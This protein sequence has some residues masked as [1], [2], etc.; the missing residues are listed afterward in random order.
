MMQNNTNPSMD[1]DE[2]YIIGMEGHMGHFEFS[3]SFTLAEDFF[4]N[5]SLMIPNF[6]TNVSDDYLD[7]PVHVDELDVMLPLDDF[8]RDLEKYEPISSGE[9]GD[10]HASLEVTEGSFHSQQLPVDGE[11]GWSLSKS[12]NSIDI[13]MDVTSIQPTLILPT[14]DMELD[15]QLSI[16]HLVQAFGEAMEKEQKELADAIVKCTREKV[17]P[18]GGIVERLLYYLFQPF[19]KQSDYLR[20]ES[21][22]NFYAAFKAFY[23]IFPYGRFAHF[24]ANSAIIHAMPHDAEIIHIVDFDMGEGVQWSSIIDA[25]G[26]QQREVRLTSIKCSEKDSNCETL[27][28]K[29]EETKRWLYDHAGS[30][31]LKL[32]VEEMELQ[33]LVSE[34]KRMKR[35]VQRKEWLVFNCNVGLPHMGRGRSRRHVMEFLRIAK[36]L[37]TYTSANCNTNNR[38]IIIVGDGDAWEKCKNSLSFGSFLDECLVHY[39]TLLESMELNF[40]IHLGEGRTAMECLFVAPS[41]SSLALIRKWEEMK[42]WTDLETGFGLRGLT[43]SEESLMEAKEIARE[44]E[45]LYGVRAEER[46]LMTMARDTANEALKDRVSHLENFVGVLK[47]NG[48]VALSVQTEQHTIELVDLRKILDDFMTETSVKITNIMEDVVSLIDVVKI[49]LKCLE[50]DVAPVKKSVLAHSGAI[51]EM[52]KPHALSLLFIV[53][54][55][56]RK[57]KI[58]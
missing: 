15:N 16:I 52:R 39:Q 21:G 51:R 10:T 23:E 33:D 54:K 11:D 17:G 47:G 49:N 6:P 42:E 44:G 2:S 12:V 36:E 29:F 26:R 7:I 46:S 37:I 14:E 13:S 32:K 45:S 34:I 25:I 58:R 41:V 27:R 1:E 3:P 43:V 5:I 55:A 40:P 20:Q 8:L 57:G 53:I 56:R 28:W 35:R 18:V 22:K 19:D 31:G 50:D 4:D 30:F 38:G 24:V 48:A 9:A